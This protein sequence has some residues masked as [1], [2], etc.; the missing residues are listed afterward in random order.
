MR[1]RTI[2]T[3]LAAGGYILHSGLSKRDATAEMAAGL[4][5]LA[6]GAFPFLKDWDP[7]D[8]V[9]RLS[10]GEMAVGSLVLM[11]LVPTRLAGLVLSGFSGGLVTMYLRTPSL[12][13]PGSIWPNQNGTAISK[14][15]WLLGIG[16]GLLLD[17][18]TDPKKKALTGRKK[19]AR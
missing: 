8:F 9:S 17:S 7:K 5:G 12:R 15:V 18:L 3:R 14:D 16:L 11:P 10:A 13:Q 6:S 4:H 1:L 2:P 19:K